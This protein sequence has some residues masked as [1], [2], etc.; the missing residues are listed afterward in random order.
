[1]LVTI[2]SNLAEGVRDD[3]DATVLDGGDVT[4][5]PAHAYFHLPDPVGHR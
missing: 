3:I 4:R 2:I 5:D 1:M